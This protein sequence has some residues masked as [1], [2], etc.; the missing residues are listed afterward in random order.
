MPRYLDSLALRDR[1][2]LLALANPANWI[3]ERNGIGMGSGVHFSAGNPSELHELPAVTGLEFEP[4]KTPY[5]K[6]LVVAPLVT[7]PRTCAE[8]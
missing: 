8:N 2:P 7:Q 1:Y 6:P 4:G 5:N 3:P